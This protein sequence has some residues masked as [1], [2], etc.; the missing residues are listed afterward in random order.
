MYLS[1]K[2][3]HDNEKNLNHAHQLINN[4][5]HV[6]KI[7]Y[8]YSN[9][10][11]KTRCIPMTTLKHASKAEWWRGQMGMLSIKCLLIL[12]TIKKCVYI[13]YPVKIKQFKEKNRANQKIQEDNVAVYHILFI[14]VITHIVIYAQTLI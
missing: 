6:L 14:K 9:H 12:Y 13:Y 5:I 7:T 10:V 8:M 1:E 2:V 4:S 11:L 3:C